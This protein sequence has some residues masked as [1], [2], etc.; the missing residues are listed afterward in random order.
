MPVRAR[1]RGVRFGDRAARLVGRVARSTSV[2]VR[3]H[4]VQGAPGGGGGGV[5]P[6]WGAASVPGGSAAGGGSIGGTDPTG[7]SGIMGGVPSS[8][9][10]APPSIGAAG[11]TAAFRWVRRNAT[12]PSTRAPAM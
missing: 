1:D 11:A 2:L 9:V 3:G 4:L 8:G 7:P 5:P 10:V 6:W 12:A